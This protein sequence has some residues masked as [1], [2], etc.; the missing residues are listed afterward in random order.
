MQLHLQLLVHAAIAVCSTVWARPELPQPNPTTN[1]PFP[2][3]APVSQTATARISDP[4]AATPEHDTGP[5]AI[6]PLTALTSSR[7]QRFKSRPI[8]TSDLLLTPGFQAPAA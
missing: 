8:S 1:M 7:G 5:V 3:S 4:E 2:P 6:N